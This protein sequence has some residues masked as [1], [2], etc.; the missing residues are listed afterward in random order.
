MLHPFFFKRPW[1]LHITKLHRHLLPL[2]TKAKK[3]KSSSSTS[4]IFKTTNRSST[5]KSANLKVMHMVIIFV[6]W[7]KFQTEPFKDDWKIHKPRHH[8]IHRSY[9]AIR[10][11]QIWTQ[12]SNPVYL[13]G[14]NDARQLRYRS[15]D[16]TSTEQTEQDH[17]A[18]DSVSE[19]SGL[20]FL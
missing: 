18:N 17:R 5:M 3:T 13:V 7:S 6:L 19:R 2:K 12:Y 4:I 11:Y 10:Y 1:L 9:V 8:T 20:D 15:A 14:K 16:D